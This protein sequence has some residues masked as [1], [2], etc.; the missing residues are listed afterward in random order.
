[1]YFE[2]IFHIFVLQDSSVCVN[3][4]IHH[5]FKS[6]KKNPKG[7][8]VTQVSIDIVGGDAHRSYKLKRKETNKMVMFVQCNSVSTW[9]HDT[10]V[11]GSML[12]KLI[13]NYLLHLEMKIVFH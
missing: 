12:R 6:D 3:C 5:N 2:L 10:G 13:F 9:T 8:N 11:V 1:M 7:G 4:F